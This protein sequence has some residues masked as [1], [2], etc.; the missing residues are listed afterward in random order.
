MQRREIQGIPDIDTVFSQVRNGRVKRVEESL[1]LGRSIA[2]ELYRQ[3]KQSYSLNRVF[4]TNSN[5]V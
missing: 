1:N 5:R 3:M 4:I 2:I